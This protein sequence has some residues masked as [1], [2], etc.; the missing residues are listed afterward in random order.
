[1]AHPESVKQQAQELFAQGFSQREIARRLG[2]SKNT[3]RRWVDPEAAR[4]QREAEARWRANNPDYTKQWYENNPDYDKTYY[5]NNKERKQEQGRVYRQANTEKIKVR[6]KKRYEENRDA[7]LEQK[8]QYHMANRDA[9]LAQK[10]VYAKNNPEKLRNNQAKRRASKRRATPPW[11]NADHHTA[12]EQLFVEALQLTKATG[13]KHH[14]DHVI[15]LTA[16]AR[17][18]GKY[19]QIACGLHVPWNLKPMPG[20]DNCRKTYKLPEPDEWTAW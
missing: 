10:K 4:K 9:I 7:I 2:V 3:I 15:P 1:M 19:I 11:Y 6:D 8:Q 12:I 17:V 18:N 20:Q 13:I 14:V 5:E 16:K